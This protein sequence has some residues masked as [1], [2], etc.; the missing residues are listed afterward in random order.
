M[1]LKSEQEKSYTHRPHHVFIHNVGHHDL[2]CDLY[3]RSGTP[4]GWHRP[5]SSGFDHVGSLLLDLLKEHVDLFIP[6]NMTEGGGAY[7]LTVPLQLDHHPKESDKMGIW[8]WAESPRSDRIASPLLTMPQHELETLLVKRIMT[9]LIEGAI[10]RFDHINFKS[11]QLVLVSSGERRRKSSPEKVTKCLTEITRLRMRVKQDGQRPEV[12][13]HHVSSSPHELTPSML[14]P[15]EQRLRE[16]ALLIAQEYGEHW[17]KALAVHI[18]ANT[19][20]TNMIVALTLTF[21]E[22]SPM[23]HLIGAARKALKSTPER[24]SNLYNANLYQLD[25]LSDWI[26][27]PRGEL[28]QLSGFAVDELRAWRD[29]FIQQRPIRP[30][31]LNAKDEQLFFHRKGLKEVLCVVIVQ[32]PNQRS[33]DD[34]VGSWHAIRGVNLEVSLPTGT[35]CAERNAIGTALCQFPQLQRGDIKAVA[36]LSL[37]EN[38]SKLGPCGACQEWLKKVIEVNPDLRIMSFSAPDADEIYI[39][40]ALVV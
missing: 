2:F 20:T 11:F 1:Q 14:L 7:E 34:Q 18:S 36:V 33:Q 26:K 23:M 39:R 40:P 28:D 15:L 22:W 38:L 3:T 13:H 31:A 24:P 21:A 32:D 8:A 17:R 19:G 6:I 37:D 12:V 27:V 29:E 9:P 16:R 4:L 10:Q 5:T 25:S 35:L 30:P